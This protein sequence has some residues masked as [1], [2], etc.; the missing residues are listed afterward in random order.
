[1][2][3]CKRFAARIFLFAKAAMLCYEI[4]KAMEFAFPAEGKPPE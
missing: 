1:M 4:E 2:Q 3:P